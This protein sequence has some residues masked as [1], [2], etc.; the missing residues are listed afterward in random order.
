MR[1]GIA[2]VQPARAA[3]AHIRL[4]VDSTVGKEV[5]VRLR[6]PAE[7][8]QSGDIRAEG[9]LPLL[10]FLQLFRRPGTGG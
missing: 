6:D 3:D 10:R 1:N 7:A 8:F 5:A 2:A 4:T 9:E